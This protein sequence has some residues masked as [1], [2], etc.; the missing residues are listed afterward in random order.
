MPPHRERGGNGSPAI[1]R[2]ATRSADAISHRIAAIGEGGM[3]SRGTRMPK[4]GAPQ[5]PHAGAQGTWGSRRCRGVGAGRI[6]LVSDELE[7]T[8]SEPG[9]AV[10]G[11]D[12]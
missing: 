8:A 11:Q 12:V 2:Y 3:V 9:S 4:Y 5:R 6:R 7:R 10:H 1:R